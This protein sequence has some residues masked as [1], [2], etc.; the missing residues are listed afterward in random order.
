M[1]FDG[2]IRTLR[3]L[4]LCGKYSLKFTGLLRE[5]QSFMSAKERTA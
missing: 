2:M 1:I 3:P 4:R 5:F